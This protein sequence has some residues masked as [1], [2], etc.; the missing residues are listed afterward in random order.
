MIGIY[1]F[2]ILM[3]DKFFSSIFIV[4]MLVVLLVLIVWVMLMFWC[5][6]FLFCCDFE[7]F[8]ILLCIKK[9]L[10]Y[11][12]SVVV[13]VIVLFFI[14]L[15]VCFV[16]I[17][18]VGCSNLYRKDNFLVFCIMDCNYYKLFFYYKFSDF[19]CYSIMRM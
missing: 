7:L 1:V 18:I 15:I 12:F 9:V 5:R 6:V 10:W 17:Y 13:V 19:L 3:N 4:K 14:F 8:L 16:L 2:C 11:N